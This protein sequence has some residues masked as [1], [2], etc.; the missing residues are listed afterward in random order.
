M[1]QLWG[2]CLLGCDIVLLGEWFFY[3]LNEC[4]VSKPS[5]KTA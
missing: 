2:S 4:S 3:V 1:C 5:K